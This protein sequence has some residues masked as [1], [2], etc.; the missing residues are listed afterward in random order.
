[1]FDLEQTDG[2]PLPQPAEIGGV[3][4]TSV[5][6][7]K[8]AIASRGILLEYADHLGGALGLSC[9]GH[10]RV[11][12]GLTPASEFA[13]LTHEFAHELL[14]RGAERPDS[15]DTR[16]LEAEAVAFVVGQDVGLDVADASGDYIHLYGG[17][18]N[19]L[20]ESLERIQQ[21]ASLILRSVGFSDL[22]SESRAGM[23]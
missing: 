15:R 11:L 21:T 8:A 23:P 12:N 22:V 18:R 17:D 10:I 2:A 1:V 5:A 14:H 16:E 19:A 13:V 7:L 20:T 6:S 9:G 3:P 4:D